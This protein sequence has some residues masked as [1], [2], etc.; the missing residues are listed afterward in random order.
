MTSSSATFDID[1]VLGRL[2]LEERAGLTIGQGAWLVAPV[3]RL[4]VPGL[5]MA[6][7][8]HGVRKMAFLDDPKARGMLPA[9]CFPTASLLGAT[10]DPALIEQVGA[11]LG[12]EARAA[13]VDVLLG[14]GVNIKRTP[15][16]GRNFEY[17]SEDPLLAGAMGAA[18]I[19]GLQAN[20][21]DACVK[22]F[23]ANNQEH[24]RF[25]IDAIVDERALRETYLPAFRA[26]VAA[27]S[28]TV[29]SAYNKV[30][31]TYA[32]EHPGLLTHL[33]R[34]EWG[35]E[36]AVI[37]DWGAVN[38]R[39][40][41]LAAG[42]D[43][44]MPQDGGDRVAETVAAVREGR[45]DEAVLDRAARAVLGLIQRAAERRSAP[46]PAG[47]QDAHH[48]LARE[49]AAAGTVLLRN[50]Q[51]DG[52]PL[53]PMPRGAGAPRRIALIGA[54]AGEPRFQGSGSSR[55]VPT[56]LSTLRAELRTRL[57][58]TVLRYLPGYRR[59]DDVDSAALRRAA[60]VEAAEAD[61]AI[62]V[63]GLPEYAE[64]EGLDRRH[65]GLPGPHD[66]LVRVVARANPRTV[67]VVV[68]G[69]PVALP[70]REEV[71]A[72][73][74]AYLGGQSAGGA[75]AD[76]LT[77]AAEPGGR[78]AETFPIA[79]ADNPVHSMPFGPRQVEYRESVFVGYRWYDTA[80][81]AVAY[82]FGHGL[83]Y[84]TFEWSAARLSTEH[85][86]AGDLVAGRL[87]VSVTVTN[88]GD[89]AGSD[90]VQAYVK[91]TDPGIF[92]PRRALAGFAKVRLEPGQSEQVTVELS[93]S[94][95]HHWDVGRQGFVIEDGAWTVC[96]STS[97][98]AVRSSHPLVTTG[99]VEPDRSPA[100]SAYR[101]L[102]P[103]HS[104]S[105]RAF[106]ELLDADV[107]DNVADRPGEFTE[108][109]PIA[110]L[111]GSPLGRRLRDL[112][113]A[114][115]RRDGT[116]SALDPHD[117]AAEVVPRMTLQ[118]G[119][120]PAMVRAIVD[121]LNGDWR[122]AARGGGTGLKEVGGRLRNRLTGLRRRSV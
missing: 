17:L 26:A 120:T 4:G 92:R 71:P 65:L 3:D 40:A 103:G 36:G 11:A 25:S 118:G 106:E 66:E 85:V 82:P 62:V 51:V 91:R 99:G 31:G 64:T 63:V 94:G 121:A 9:T 73:V 42:L 29:M 84:T 37:S 45:L 41:S 22:H 89:R 21:A 56:R 27:G 30:N 53:L 105:R 107:P 110:D 80:D 70:W 87:A 104:F 60:V 68:S 23:A 67:V 32:T 54:F 6:D 116:V 43:L 96:V 18:W 98:S 39:V 112:V 122:A 86:S 97:V 50:E 113:A 59:H 2:T 7:G 24:R 10:W 15:L 35:F 114:A 109:T 76:V 19:R 79:L 34:D 46:S 12:R 119:L 13:G 101:S 55:V 38:D 93:S 74:Q 95:F 69:A 78:L 115:L 52:A 83:S 1:E 100:W 61:L 90:V 49:V 14:P 16:C 47:D 88:T 111:L 81:L 33:L 75:I 58:D 102:R 77:G 44:Q 5:T 28:A 20:G 117:L 57:P 108:N 72:V 48:R 8:P